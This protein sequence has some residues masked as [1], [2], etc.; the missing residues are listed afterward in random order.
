MNRPLLT[1][2]AVFALAVGLGLLLLGVVFLIAS[3]GRATRLPVGLVLGAL[4]VAAIAFALSRLKLLREASPQRVMARV[5]DLAT[6][7]GGEVTLGQV[8]G[9]LGLPTDMAERALSDLAA[10][11]MCTAEV[12]GQETF[13]VFAGI[14]PH[15]ITRQCPYC[16]SEFSVREARDTCPSCG[17]NLKLG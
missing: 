5:A 9:D 1:C 3:A 7:S 6:R 2:L 4:G 11:G 12:R 14:Q 15:K 17:A 10:R 8:V 16:G 13:Y